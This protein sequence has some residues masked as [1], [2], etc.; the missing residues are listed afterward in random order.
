M[1]ELIFMDAG[2]K[3]GKKVLVVKRV[4]TKEETLSE[5]CGTLDELG[6]RRTAKQAQ[7]ASMPTQ[8]KEALNTLQRNADA[9][10]RKLE[11][12]IAQLDAAIEH[13]SK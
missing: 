7:L 3:D 6:Q 2:E 13:L 12:E 10:K 8:L 5:C 11:A 4:T 9:E 1:S